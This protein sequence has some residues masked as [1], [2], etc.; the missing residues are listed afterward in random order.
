MALQLV[1]FDMAGTTVYDN[2]FVLHCMLQA[3]ARQGIRPDAFR[4]N[5]LMGYPKKIAIR[6]VL[7][8]EGLEFSDDMVEQLHREFKENMLEFY[9]YSPE[10]SAA[11]GAEDIFLYLKESNVKVALNTGFS[12][13]IAQTILARFQWMERGLIDDFICSDEVERGRPYP[14]M[15]HELKERLGIGDD[16]EVMK[17]GDAPVDIEEGRNADCD[18]IVGITTGSFTRTQLEGLGATHIID[19]LDEL[20]PLVSLAASGYAQN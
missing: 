3:F 20:S 18:Y 9:E 8:E 10:V 19:S 2:D 5:T 6:T 14:D 13:D 15:I 17:V 12:R 7:E 1:V 11:Q 4:V 16:A